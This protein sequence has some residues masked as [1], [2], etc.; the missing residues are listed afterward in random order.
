MKNSIEVPK[1]TKNRV[2]MWFSN[3]TFEHISGENC[4]LKRSMHPMFIAALFTITKTWK[5][6]KYSTD[7]WIKKR[8][9]YT[10]EYY[11]AFK[12]EWN[13]AICSNMDGTRDYH[14]KSV[15]REK[16]EGDREDGRWRSNMGRSPAS[17]QIHQK[18]IKG[19]NNSYKATSRWQ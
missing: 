10:M 2:F 7:E 15:Q 11:S 19:W 3:P 14:T 5:Q 18:L 9:I 13:N 17:L 8:Y 6:S 1:K 16:D 4:N 12:K